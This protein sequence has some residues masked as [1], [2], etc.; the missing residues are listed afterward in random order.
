[1]SARKRQRWSFLE[2]LECRILP[3]VTVQTGVLLEETD[4][5]DGIRIVGGN[6]NSR[7]LIDDE[8][9]GAGSLLINVDANGDGDFTDVGDTLNLVVPVTD[10]TCVIEILM[11]GGNDIVAYRLQGNLHESR[12]VISVNLGNGN[13]RFTFNTQSFDIT[14]ESVVLLEVLGGSGHDEASVAIGNVLESNLVVETALGKGNDIFRFNTSNH[15]IA[16]IDDGAIVEVAADVGPGAN[17]F[18]FFNSTLVGGTIDGQLLMDLTGG[19]GVDTVQG[20]WASSTGNGSDAS[21]TSL[22]MQ[23]GGGNDVVDMTY[24]QLSVAVGSTSKTRVQGGDGNDSLK[25]QYADE[26]PTTI[27][28]ELQFDLLGGTGDD[29]IDVNLLWTLIGGAIDLDGRLRLNIFGQEGDDDIS[30]QARF[31]DVSLGNYSLVVMSGSGDDKVRA[32]V[33][34]GSTL[35]SYGRFGKLALSGGQG[36]DELLSTFFTS[37]FLDPIQFELTSTQ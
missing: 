16:S 30:A 18:E 28:G 19:S 11:G 17:K 22:S 31:D 26:N 13:D 6:E 27:Y 7:V 5:S 21:L 20:L 4:N 3:A 14:E 24:Y 36:F 1:M 35:L 12:R 23:L 9:D 15:G 32:V 33:E 2:A 37:P 29:V 8:G 25:F 34:T 10:D